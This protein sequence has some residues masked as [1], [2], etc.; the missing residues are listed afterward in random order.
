MA[1]FGHGRHQV[2]SASVTT[3]YWSTIHV[4]FDEFDPVDSV[5]AGAAPDTVD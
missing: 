4:G 5:D 3:V 1:V 2:T